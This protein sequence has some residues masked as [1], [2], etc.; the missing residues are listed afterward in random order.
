MSIRKKFRESS[1]LCQFAFIFSPYVYIIEGRYLKMTQTYIDTFA[2][3]EHKFMITKA[4]AEEITGMIGDHLKDDAH[5]QYTLH[6]IYYDSPDSQMIAASL[7]HPMYKEKLRLRSYGDPVEGM[8]VFA[9]IKKKYDGIVYKRRTMLDLDDAERFLDHRDRRYVK[10]RTGAE[11]SFML[12][13]YS[14]ERKLYISY[15]RRAYAGKQEADVRITFDTDIRY[16]TDHLDLFARTEDK[17]LLDE[18][19]VLMEVK[20]MN[21]YPLWLTDAL[22]EMHICRTSFSKYG[23]IYTLM[24]ASPAHGQIYNCGIM[25]QTE[26]RQCLVQY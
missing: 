16:R 19:Q 12:E 5:P 1:H 2:R 21:R 22:T 14:A 17:P 13:R 23:K 4:Q 6:N 20:V 24:H 25:P 11:I 15:S 26:V 3:V 10:D 7:E 18:D 9:E 8:P